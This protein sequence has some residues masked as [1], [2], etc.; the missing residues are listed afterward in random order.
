M[1]LNEFVR[2]MPKTELH[3]HL[4][5]SIRPGTVLQLANR[6]HIQLPAKDEAGLR[7]FYKF[8]NFEHFIQVYFFVTGCLRVPDDYRL[9]AYEFGSDCA[10]QNIRYA[11]VTFT[12]ET[13][14]RLNKL[15]WESILEGLNA[16][17][18][19]ANEE[20]GVDWRWIFD[21][22]RNRPGPQEKQILQIAL[23][24]LQ[25]GCIALGLGGSELQYPGE[26]FVDIF[27]Q[28]HQAG[29]PCIPH[30]G[31][32][33][34][35]PSVR[36]AIEG[37]HAQRIQHGVRAI[38]DPT[39][40][41]LLAKE[42]ITLDVCPTSNICLG[43]Y[44]DFAAHPLRK[45][46]DE[47]VTLTIGSDDPPM[48]NTNL[49]QEYQVLIE[50]FDFQIEELEQISLNGLYASMLPEAEKKRLVQA[51]QEEFHALKLEQ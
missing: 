22:N 13:N 15:P 20:F 6:N 37:L 27:D 3:V 26:L 14:M 29:L 2:R 46:W 24:S 34:G 28:A 43:I 51:F 41:H 48:F 21:I 32:T 17:R 47:G 40:V 18:E 30:A 50:H 9:I 33:G 31:E 16:G 35:A 10:R 45:L 49:T 7:E 8:R 44:P 36:Q 25:A 19:Q 42:G 12:F 23:D 11:E 1:D 38:E 4:E 39:L 5:G